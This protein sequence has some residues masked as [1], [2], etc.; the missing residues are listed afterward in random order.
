[1]ATPKKERQFIKANSSE[2]IS[3]HV[4]KNKEQ[5]RENALPDR[6]I[7]VV[8]WL[9]GIACEVVAILLLNKTIWP[10]DKPIMG[11][12][13]QIFWILVALILDMI[14]VIIGSQFWK[15]GNDKDPASREN[16]VRFFLQNQMG[17][18]VACL[19]F[20]PIIII[21]LNNK[22]LDTKTKRIVTAVAAVALMI[23]GLAS[24]DWDAPSQEELEQAIVEYGNETVYWTQFG[25]KYHLD[26]DCQ[27]IVNSNNIFYGTIDESYEAGRTSP[28]KFCVQ[29]AENNN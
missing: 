16:P 4:P 20:F 18:I 17:L 1:M 6:I 7:A 12:H 13:P 14:L 19:A 11:L 3:Q 24:V 10:G 21:L 25:K 23:T 22:D 8:F 29:H 15:R 2:E 28:C 26:K 5:R 27:A 9:L